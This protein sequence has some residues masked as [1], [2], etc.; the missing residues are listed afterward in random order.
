MTRASRLVS[1]DG[2]EVAITHFTSS[3]SVFEGINNYLPRKRAPMRAEHLVRPIDRHGRDTS[4][5]SASHGGYG[6]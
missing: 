6:L 1:E 5:D 4:A 2:E 3:G